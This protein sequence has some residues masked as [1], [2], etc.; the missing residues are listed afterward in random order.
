[1][2][3]ILT[4]VFSFTTWIVFSGKF[5]LFHLSL[6]VIA[7]LLVT[8]FSGDFFWG[9]KSSRFRLRLGFIPNFI[10]YNIWLIAEI[11]RANL[12]VFR[13]AFHPKVRE[14]I[15]PQIFQ[16]QTSLKSDFARF[17]LGNSI[18]LT[19]GTVT[20]KIEGDIFTI[21]AISDQAAASLP[22]EMERRVAKVFES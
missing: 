14:V 15:E 2:H 7:S 17:V 4:F 21:H 8:N 3:H 11:F 16:F 13:L 18:T 20:L 9:D 1:M 22:G 10:G 19:P 5:D 12:H 6:G